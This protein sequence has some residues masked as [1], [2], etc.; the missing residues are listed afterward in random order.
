MAEALI[1]SISGVRG[2]VGE[3][4]DANAA[5]RFSQALAANLEPGAVTVSG[6]SRPSGR[7]LMRLASA[8]LESAGREVIDLGIVP[9]P[10]VGVAVRRLGSRLAHRPY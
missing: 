3:S 6:D 5:L 10:T 2:I 4:L 9:T 1:V 8:A 7:W